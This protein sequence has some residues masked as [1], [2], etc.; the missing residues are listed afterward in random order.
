MRERSTAYVILGVLAVGGDLSGYEIRR[1][2]T[3]AVGFFW[4]E[5]YGQIYPELRRLTK[6]GL[7]KAL[8]GDTARN[9]QRYRLLKPGQAKLRDWLG[10]KPQPERPRS[11]ALLKLFFGSV[12]TGETSRA[13]LHGIAEATRARAAAL[14]DAESAA[15]TGERASPNL[16]HMLITILSG[17]RAFAARLAWADD[18][19]ALLDAHAKGGNAAVLRAYEKLQRR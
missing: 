9:V 14:D 2:I 6:A 16:V 18:A 15:L 11:E 12:A 8:P 17:R 10:K 3:D 19:Q 1:W 5:S 7:I 4:S 13:I